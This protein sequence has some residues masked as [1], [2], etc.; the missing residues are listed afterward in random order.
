[1]VLQEMMKTTAAANGGLELSL[2]YYELYRAR[3]FD[4]LNKV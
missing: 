2:S 1:M 3:P 4:L